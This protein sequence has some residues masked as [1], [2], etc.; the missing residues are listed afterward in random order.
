MCDTSN[1]N[2]GLENDQ[3]KAATMRDTSNT[4]GIKSHT[5]SLIGIKFHDGSFNCAPASVF[6]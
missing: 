4:T 1:S 6:S 5:S 2:G 3:F